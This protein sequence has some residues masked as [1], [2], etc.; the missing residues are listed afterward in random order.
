MDPGIIRQ[1]GVERGDEDT[2]VAQQHGLAVELGQHLHVGS[3]VADARRADEHSPER[4]LV[5]VELEIRLEARDLPSVRVP[6][7]LQ[8]GQPE[9]RAVE[10]DHP[11]ARPE[12]RRRERAD[13][14]V[15]PVERGEPEDRRRLPARDHETVEP[16]ELTGQAHLD[17][18]RAGLAQDAR[19]LAERALQRENTDSGSTSHTP[20]V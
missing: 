9:V 15:E 8:V 17:D 19:V 10:Q 4:A 12:D 1:L 6:I 13:R 7:D 2:P 14:L 20:K 3:D 18:V 5:S 11:R 16:V